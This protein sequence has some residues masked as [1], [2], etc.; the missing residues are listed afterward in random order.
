[1]QEQRL[2]VSPTNK[3]VARENVPRS[4]EQGNGCSLGV[5]P[6]VNQEIAHTS[7]GGSDEDHI[8]RYLYRQRSS[9][10]GAGCMLKGSCN[11]PREPPHRG[12]LKTLVRQNEKSCEAAS[13]E[14]ASLSLLQLLPR[15]GKRFPTLGLGSGRA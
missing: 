7:K 10:E 14:T 15:F 12:G 8:G 4:L 1:M 13:L 6:M 5:H 11:R 2:S 9:W 3:I